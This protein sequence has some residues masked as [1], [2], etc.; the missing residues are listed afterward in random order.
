MY[1]K[2]C[3]YIICVGNNTNIGSDF[4][5]TC[6]LSAPGEATKFVRAPRVP[7]SS[8]PKFVR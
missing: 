3:E 2:S 7:N 4:D 8:G 1:C 6:L 5:M